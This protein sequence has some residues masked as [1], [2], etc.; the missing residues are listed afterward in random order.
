[1]VS[2]V[3]S[4]WG[5]EVLGHFWCWVR[6]WV[7]PSVLKGSW[8]TVGVGPKPVPVSCEGP[9]SPWVPGEGVLGLGDAVLGQ[10]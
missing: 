3:L 2:R 7:S 10:S 6:S 5:R 1:M 4:G 9:G 8:V